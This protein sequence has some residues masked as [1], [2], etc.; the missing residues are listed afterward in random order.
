MRYIFYAISI[1]VLCFGWYLEFIYDVPDS[2]ITVN[3]F[4]GWFLVVIGVSSL[5]INLFWTEPNRPR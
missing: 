5:L 4:T 3:F 1:A 2:Q